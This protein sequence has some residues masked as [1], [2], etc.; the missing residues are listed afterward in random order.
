MAGIHDTINSGKVKM[1]ISFPVNQAS[2]AADV[3]NP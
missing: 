3:S 2:K 1:Y